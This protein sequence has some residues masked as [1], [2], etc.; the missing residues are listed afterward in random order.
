VSERQIDVIHALVASPGSGEPRWLLFP[1]G[2]WSA[3]PGLPLL[4]LP[5]K[6]VA[7]RGKG[8]F[9]SRPGMRRALALLCDEIGVAGARPAGRLL[10]LTQ[11][12]L[13][14]PTAGVATEYRIAPLAL[15]LAGGQ[16]RIARRVGGEWLT[17]GEALERADLSPTARVVL[18]GLHE[19][20]GAADLA[21]RLFG[22]PDADERTRRLAE[23]RWDDRLFGPLFEQMRPWLTE[24]LRAD[25]T[26]A[27]LFRVLGDVDDA[28][29]DAALNALTSLAA[30][31][32]ARGTADGWLWVI[33]RN[34]GVT[35]LRQRRRH[36]TVGDA[37]LGGLAGRGDDPAE[38]AEGRER[39]ERVRRRLDS[40]LGR[41]SAPVRQAWEA[42]QGGGVTYE[43]VAAATG[44]PM[45]TLAATFHRLRHSLR[46]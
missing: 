38:W 41:L 27:A 24:R 26:T 42:Y 46:D 35:V 37:A 15:P 13:H 2:R 16:E 33:T 18:T 43:E 25:A 1:H 17:A 28:L 44:V 32:P 40:A 12:P 22:A 31:D 7:R 14:S 45:G 30:F 19:I 20:A 6:K 29:S 10:P 39:A 36:K 34:A 23:A 9:F 11:L 8:T 21:R 3:G 5:A 4:A